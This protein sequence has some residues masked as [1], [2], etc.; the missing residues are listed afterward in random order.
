MDELKPLPCPFC[1]GEEV[2]R[3]LVSMASERFYRIECRKCFA[4]TG[5]KNTTAQADAAWNR[6]PQPDNTPLTLE[7]LRGMGGGRVWL[8]DTGHSA[9]SG[10]HLVNAENEFLIDMYGWKIPLCCLG[11][12]RIVYRRKPEP[13]GGEG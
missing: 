13:E 10:W 11:N 7:E 5:L 3:R 9:N 12:E 4:T 8:D 1:G 6:R 2:E